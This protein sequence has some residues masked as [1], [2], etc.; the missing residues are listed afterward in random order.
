[1]LAVWMRRKFDCFQAVDFFSV[2]ECFIEP[3]KWRGRAG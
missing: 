2:C 1:L 3:G